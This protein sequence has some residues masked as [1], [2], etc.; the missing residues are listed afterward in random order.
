[1]GFRRLRQHR[2][3]ARQDVKKTLFCSPLASGA[4][5]ATQQVSYCSTSDLSKRLVHI[6]LSAGKRRTMSRYGF[7]T[8]KLIKDLVD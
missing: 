6:F 4:Q 8:S 5:E 2:R 7:S 1:V 3:E